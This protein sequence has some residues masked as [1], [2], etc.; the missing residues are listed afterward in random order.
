MIWLMANVLAALE[1]RVVSVSKE[2]VFG[3][4]KCYMHLLREWVN[5]YLEHYWEVTR[6]WRDGDMYYIAMEYVNDFANL[7]DD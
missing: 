4:S 5:E 3:A 2:I 7:W 6:T 1:A